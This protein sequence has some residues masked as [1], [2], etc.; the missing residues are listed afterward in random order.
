MR[1][2]AKI[3]SFVVIADLIDSPSLILLD[4]RPS[5]HTVC[6]SLGIGLTCVAPRLDLLDHPIARSTAAEQTQH[7]RHGEGFF[8]RFRDQQRAGDESLS[9]RARPV[10]VRATAGVLD[11]GEDL[12]GDLGY[13]PEAFRRFPIDRVER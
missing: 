5:G 7:P 13:L 11:F 12:V 8:R 10:V 6:D 2:E 4:G 3:C 1:G 9:R